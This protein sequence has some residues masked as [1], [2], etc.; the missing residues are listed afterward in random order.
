MGLLDFGGGQGRPWAVVG[1]Q[2]PA[3]TSCYW[4]LSKLLGT[5]VKLGVDLGSPAGVPGV[6]ELWQA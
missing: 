3:L 1:H 4:F 5:A 6:L 2:R